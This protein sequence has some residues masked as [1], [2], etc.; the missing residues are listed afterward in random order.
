M[1]PTKSNNRHTDAFAATSH[2]IEN[3]CM[4]PYVLADICHA[5]TQVII[6]N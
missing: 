3:F 6:T 4:D 1:Q 2:S 5:D